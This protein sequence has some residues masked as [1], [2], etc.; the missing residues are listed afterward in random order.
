MSFEDLYPKPIMRLA[1]EAHGAGRLPNPDI[2]V[3]RINPLCG[4]KITVDLSMKDEIVTGL[5]YEVKACVLCQASASALGGSIT[6]RT[7]SEIK[8]LH[9]LLEAMLKKSGPAPAGAFSAF[10][11]LSPVKEHASRHGCVLL[12]LDAVLEGLGVD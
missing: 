1:A 2:T 10:D 11:V 12:P 4:D 3:T 7:S 8:L 9:G 5:G 6:G